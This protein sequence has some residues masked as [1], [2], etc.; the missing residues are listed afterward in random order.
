MRRFRL[1]QVLKLKEQIEYKKKSELKLQYDILN[2]YVE[3][4]I[5][6]ENQLN[7]IKEQMSKLMTFG[8]SPMQ[9][10]HYNQFLNGLKKKIEIQNQLIYYQQLKVEE[11]KKELIESMIDKKKYEK[12][13][14]KHLQQ[15]LGQIKQD[16][17]SE[18]DRVISYKIYKSLGDNNG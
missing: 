3:N 13:K 16:E 8:F 7:Y 1:E 5:Q 9:M 10:K 15:L 11:K 2:R 4:K 14:E 18:I 17:N 6:L 12:L